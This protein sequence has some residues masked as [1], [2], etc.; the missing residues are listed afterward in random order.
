MVGDLRPDDY[1]RANRFATSLEKDV[2]LLGGDNAKKYFSGDYKLSGSSIG[3][4]LEN[5][6][7]SGLRFSAAGDSDRQAYNAFY[8]AL[9][10]YDAG[11]QQLAGPAKPAAPG[12]GPAFLPEP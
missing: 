8:N 4:V 7:R 3:E 1:I 12:K 6:F 2:V 5:V 10:Q 9:L 11:L